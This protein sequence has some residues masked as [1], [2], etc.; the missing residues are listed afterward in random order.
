MQWA[1]ALFPWP[2]P[3]SKCVLLGKVKR[4][5]LLRFLKLEAEQAGKEKWL[6]QGQ[7][8]LIEALGSTAN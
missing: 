2:Y 8:R 6:Q 1:G 4:L 3:S 5:E 7:K